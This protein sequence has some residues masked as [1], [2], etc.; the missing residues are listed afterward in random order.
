M[1]FFEMES[2]TAVGWPGSAGDPPVSVSYAY[3]AD[4]SA[5]MV[6]I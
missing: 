4:R 2:L 3:L 5:E 1:L 6:G